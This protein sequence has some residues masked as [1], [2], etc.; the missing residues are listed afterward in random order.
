M[1]AR[2]RILL[3]RHCQSEANAAGRIEGHGDSPLS[4]E[5]RAQALEVGR[6]V[7][8]RELADVR[9]LASNQARAIATAEAIGAACGWEL[10]ARDPRIREGTLGWMEDMSYSEVGK[11]MAEQGVTILD[12]TVHGGES[13]DAV[14]DRIWAALDE[15]MADHAG[16][17]VVVSHGYTIQALLRRLDPDV[18]IPRFIGNGDLVEVWLEAGALAEAPT[19]HPLKAG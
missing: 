18:A 14:A 13:L 19:H 15:A 17:L 12:A 4:E 8:A 3:V 5:G 2:R 9:L 11:H 7:A 1:T 10:A 16:A 6:R